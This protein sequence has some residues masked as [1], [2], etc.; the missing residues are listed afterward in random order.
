MI[1]IPRR[2]RPGKYADR[3]DPCRS[4]DAPAW[5]NGTRIVS[6][7]SDGDAGISRFCDIVRRRVRCSSPV[8]LEKD[9]TVYED[10]AHPHRS[11][12]LDVVA[13]AVADVEVGD[14]SLTETAAEH[15]CSRDSVR[16]WIGWIE[17]LA[18][19]RDLERL[20]A[21]IDPEGVPGPTR[22][23]AP[24]RAAT[25]LGLL[26]RLADLF[27][28]RGLPI[29]RRGTGLQRVLTDRLRRFG[30]VFYLTIFSP[31]LRADLRD[32]SV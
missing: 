9:W 16:R 11:F 8:C 17:E 22:L 14:Q 18:E 19:P 7:V 20:I 25:I 5:W 10:G 3:P 31:P 24:S 30:E 13:S 6:S 15:E 29:P 1:S 23:T 2:Q 28:M 32:L 12:Q 21:R 27:A 4:C 26:E